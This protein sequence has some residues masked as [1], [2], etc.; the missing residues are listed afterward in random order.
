MYDLFNKQKTWT[1][2]CQFKTDLDQSTYIRPILT[3][4]ENKGIFI[5][6]MKYE[7]ND[8]VEHESL[9]KQMVTGESTRRAF[10]SVNLSQSSSIY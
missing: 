4:E 6:L 1:R 2:R 3:C 9:F 5:E 8:G 10:D 7:Y